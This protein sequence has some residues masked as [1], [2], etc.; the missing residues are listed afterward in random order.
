M[1]KVETEFRIAIDSPDHIFASESGTAVDYF[2]SGYFVR[3][4]ENIL[5]SPI[6]TID[7]GCASGRQTKE[8]TLR[9]HLAVGLEGSDWSFRHQRPDWNVIPNNLFTCDCSKPFQI[10]YNGQPFIADVITLFGVF[11][12]F[13]EEDLPT[14]FDNIKKHLRRQG[15]LL[16]NIGTHPDRHDYHQ[17]VRPKNWWLNLLSQNEFV[18]HQE[19]LD[20][21]KNAWPRQDSASLAFDF[22][23]VKE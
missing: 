3:V 13:K 14:V 16:G 2:G 17:T 5:Q 4:L 11:E 21:F 12:H 15:I 9:E 7:I 23:C 8:F 10:T 22:F 19:K 6:R 18:F 1:F 20:L